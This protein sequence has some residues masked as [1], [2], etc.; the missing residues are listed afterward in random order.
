MPSLKTLEA[1]SWPEVLPVP[2]GGRLVPVPCRQRTLFETG[3]LAKLD[4]SP[5]K[6]DTAVRDDASAHD[7]RRSFSER[8]S[9]R[10]MPQVL[11]DL[12]RHE[13]IETTLRYYV[14]RNA[15]TITD[16]AWVA[17]EAKKSTVLSTSRQEGDDSATL[18][19]GATDC[20]TSG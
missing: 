5:R 8:W 7:L 16:A 3:E 12:M 6:R 20:E 18:V 9:V 2:M 13:S 17:R 1:A 14:G 19:E 10:V 4:C 11:K 15:Q